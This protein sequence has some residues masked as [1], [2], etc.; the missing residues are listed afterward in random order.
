MVKV[1]PSQQRTKMR[2]SVNRKQVNTDWNSSSGV[3]QLLNKPSVGAGTATSVGLSSTDLAISGSPITTSGSFTANLNTSGVGAGTYSGV[4]VTTK[5]IV[6]S[7]TTRSFN[8]APGRS[9]VTGTGATGFQVS[10]TRDA[11]VA[12]SVGIVTTA[13]IGSGQDGYIAME[14]ASTNSA[15]PSDWVE[16]GRVRNGQTFTLAVAVQGVQTIAGDLA[17]IIPAGYYLKYRS[18]NVIGTPTTS[19]VSGQEVLL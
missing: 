6:T 14:V 5:G 1:Y 12:A 10:A 18:V 8:N 9:I 11:Q 16:I 7:G 2:L 4:T 3:S 17:R 15:T 19:W 13:S